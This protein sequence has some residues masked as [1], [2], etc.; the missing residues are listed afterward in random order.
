MPIKVTN[1]QFLT[2][3][4]EKVGDEYIP[5]SPYKKA[6]DKVL[7]L[8]K[9]CGRTFFQTP[10]HFLKDNRRCTY[11]THGNAKSPEEFKKEFDKVSNGCYKLLS[12]YHRSTEKV[13]ILH[14]DCGKTYEVTPKAFLKGERCPYCNGNPR[15]TTEQFSKEVK[16]LTC[17]EYLCISEY[18]NNRVKVRI[19]HKKC[20]HTYLVT[21]H[22]FLNGNRCPYC[23]QSKGEKM[24][25]NTLKRLS[26]PYEI[27]KAFDDCGRNNQW[28]PFD[29]YLSSI[30]LLIEYDGI[31]HFEP[32]PYYGG[33]SKLIDQKR[34]DHI[35]D[36]YALDHNLEILRVPY[37]L[38]F[39]HV[40]SCLG[41]YIDK[42]KADGL[43][44][45]V[46]TM[47]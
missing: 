25:E 47:I 10:N 6:T 24:I 41:S 27:Q 28:L 15:K 20:G 18:T 35:K 4:R 44:P 7:F 11:C 23:K 19:T 33:Y 22:D 37:T 3:V 43:V 31:Q 9:T 13:K 2:R 21:P 42:R 5:L 16:D 26:I 12:E 32:V 39:E 38:A 17:G 29:F 36:E 30:G 34:R 1:E 45:K 8:H 14:I 40:E 46:E